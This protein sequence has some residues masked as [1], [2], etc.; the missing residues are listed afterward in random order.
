MSIFLAFAAT[1]PDVRV[2]L[3]FVIPVKVK[4]LGII[5]FV[6]M[7]YDAVSY[8]FT[9]GL[10]ITIL[11]L[12]II[13]ASLLNFFIFFISTRRGMRRTHSQVKMAREYKR[14][15]ENVQAQ[16]R[17]S[18]HKCAICG[19]TSDSHPDLQFRFCS[20]CEGGYEYCQDHL[21]T[22]KHIT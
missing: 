1:Y 3:F 22:H 16:S 17:I 6:I 11:E 12:V 8:A 7:I 15:T 21:F 4:F 20:K 13:F 5:Y 19:R 14:K 2:Y 9:G 10:I 18:K